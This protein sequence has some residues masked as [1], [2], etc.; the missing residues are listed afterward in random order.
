MGLDDANWIHGEDPAREASRDGSVTSDEETSCDGT[1]DEEPGWREE[2]GWADEPGWAD[3]AGGGRR[4]DG[5]VSGRVAA[6]VA[7]LAA[8]A[9]VAA[10]LLIVRAS[11]PAPAVAAAPSPSA[12]STSLPGHSGPRD[13]TLQIRL[14]GRVLAVSDHS[15]SIGGAGPTVTAAITAATK[16]TGD[17]RGVAGIKVG[18]EVSAQITGTSGHLTATAIRD[19]ASQT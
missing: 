9:G 13:G 6:A 18:A 12:V 5:G 7:V 17:V 1:W 3:Q 15:I 16:I 8:A 4:G 11:A 14:T 19:P 2:S 10:A